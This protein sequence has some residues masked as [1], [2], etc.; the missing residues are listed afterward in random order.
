MGY[1]YLGQCYLGTLMAVEAT[2]PILGGNIAL[3]WGHAVFNDISKISNVNGV[4]NLPMVSPPYSNGTT[5][6]TSING[7][8]L[9]LTKIS[10]TSKLVGLIFVQ[11]VM[12]TTASQV[13]NFGILVDGTDYLTS[14]Q[15]FNAVN[16]H[17]Q[18]IG[19]FIVP[20]LTA[21]PKTIQVRAKESVA[22]GSITVDVNDRMSMIVFEIP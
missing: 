5:A 8:T 10:N 17:T 19:G 4:F 21:G 20:N 3:A 9:G 16:V 7:W 15:W 22:S 1:R 14:Q 6:F 13:V 11:C 2:D 18:V 12:S